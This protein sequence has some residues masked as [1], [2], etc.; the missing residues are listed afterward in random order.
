[1]PTPCYPT[2]TPTPSA[3]VHEVELNDFVVQSVVVDDHHEYRV[4]RYGSVVTQSH[5]GFGSTG[6]ALYSGLQYAVWMP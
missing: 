2:P 1:M 5:E 4:L 6:L 3:I